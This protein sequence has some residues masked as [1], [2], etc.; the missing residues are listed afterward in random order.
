M[1]DETPKPKTAYVM[2]EVEYDPA[3]TTP[4]AIADKIER[5]IDNTVSTDGIWDECISDTL[6]SPGLG[7]V[8]H[9]SRPDDLWTSDPEYPKEDWVMEV[10]NGDTVAS[11]YEWVK[12]QK[13]AQQ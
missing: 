4:E 9:V 13:E 11:Y 5:F 1:S 10:I 12:A 6:G 8:Y 3:T 2:V 7:N